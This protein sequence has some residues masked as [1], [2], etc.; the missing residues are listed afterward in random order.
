MRKIVL[1]SLVVSLAS[2]AA[3]PIL[4]IPGWGPPGFANLGKVVSFFESEGS[5]RS[6]LHQFSY[7]YK[8]SLGTIK[9]ALI[10]KLVRTIESYSANTRFDV[11]THSLGHFVAL[12]ALLESGFGDRIDHYIGLA[13]VGLGQEDLP[14]G[15]GI[16][17]CTAFEPLIPYPSRFALELVKRFG[18]TFQHWK[19]CSLYSVDDNLLD[20]P[21][22]ASAFPDGT[23]IELS[24]YRHNDFIRLR[25]IY[26]VM[27]AACG[28]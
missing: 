18:T 20:N 13:G 9:K 7:P 24:G 1:F 3:N 12:H 26:E 8:K 21:F 14:P 16:A 22:D 6:N 25:E 17:S 10:P 11:V 4:F 2:Y 23:N 19:K 27:R 28:I 15:C 5:A